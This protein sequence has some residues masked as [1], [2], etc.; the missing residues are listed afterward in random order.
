MIFL[1]YHYSLLFNTIFKQELHKWNLFLKISK[2]FPLII[3]KISNLYT[4]ILLTSKCIEFNLYNAF[5]RFKL[6]VFI[7]KLLV[8]PSYDI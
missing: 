1:L 3:F 4:D 7:C 5:F 8:N 2:S 6:V